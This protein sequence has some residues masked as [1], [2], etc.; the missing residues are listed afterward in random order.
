MDY[1]QTLEALGTQDIG[2]I[3]TK[4]KHNTENQKDEQHEL[5]K[6]PCVNPGARED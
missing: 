2:R 6:N 1:P 4:Q 5:N 3:Q